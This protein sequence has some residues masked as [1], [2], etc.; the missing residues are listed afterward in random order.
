[1]CINETCSIVRA[2]KRLSDTFAI[3]NGLKQ[4]VALTSLLFNVALE[5][6]IRRVQTNQEGLK[7]KGTHQ[8]LIYADDVIILGGSIH[9]IQKIT[10]ALTFACMEI[11]LKVCKC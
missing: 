1:M 6:A 9:T 5:C 4:G 11:G 2:A 7:L 10:E 8:L 3:N